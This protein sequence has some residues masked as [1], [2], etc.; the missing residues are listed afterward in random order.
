MNCGR[1]I[2]HAFQ[3][4]TKVYGSECVINLFGNEK[5]VKNQIFLA[6]AWNKISSQTKERGMKVYKMTEDQLFNQYIKTG[7]I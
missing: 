3:V 2:E 4:G 5:E 1:E 6:K 7:Q